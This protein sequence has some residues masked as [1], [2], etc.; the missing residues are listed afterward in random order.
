M[1]QKNIIGLNDIFPLIVESN[2]FQ[3][4]QVHAFRVNGQKAIGKCWQL[5]LSLFMFRDGSC[6]G[7]N[8]AFSAFCTPFLLL[9]L[10]IIMW[11]GW[12]VFTNGKQWKSSI[13]IFEHRVNSNDSITLIS[14][15][16]IGCRNL[17]HYNILYIKFVFFRCSC[18]LLF[19][20]TFSWNW[21][22]LAEN[23]IIA[24]CFASTWAI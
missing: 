24:T 14:P 20:N 3:R 16:V 15:W 9:K 12:F 17:K 7:V 18:S 19:V 2:V 6:S 10:A 8:A 13:N 11:H 1:L 21:Q 23:S 4:E 5:N 22:K